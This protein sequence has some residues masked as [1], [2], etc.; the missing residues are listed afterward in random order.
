MPFKFELNQPVEITTSSE[1]GTVKG[2]AEYTN[3]ANSYWLQYQAADGRAC[4]AWWDEDALSP[5]SSIS[6]DTC[7]KTPKTEVAP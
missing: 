3:S 5:S 7:T 6:A 1:R 4:N 2:R